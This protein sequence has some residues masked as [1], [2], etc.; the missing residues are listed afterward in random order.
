MDTS[1]FNAHSPSSTLN[2][3]VYK[4]YATPSQ[5]HMDNTVLAHCSGKTDHNGVHQ[6]PPTDLHRNIGHVHNRRYLQ[7]NTEVLIR[8]EFIH[9]MGYTHCKIYSSLTNRP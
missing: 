8:M 5:V 1:K 3:S 7:P 4:M 9:N 6:C 2:I